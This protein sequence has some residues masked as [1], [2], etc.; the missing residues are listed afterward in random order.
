MQNKNKK[1]DFEHGISGVTTSQ[2]HVKHYL[3]IQPKYIHDL[4]EL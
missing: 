2:I 4:V 1:W 3:E